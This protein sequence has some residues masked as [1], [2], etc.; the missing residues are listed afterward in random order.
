TNS[1]KQQ[2]GLIEVIEVV[3]DKSM[4]KVIWNSE[5]ICSGD[6]LQ[7]SDSSG[8]GLYSLDIHTTG[9][10]TDSVVTY[11]GSMGFEIPFKSSGKVTGGFTPL[12]LSDGSLTWVWNFGFQMGWEL[13]IIPGTLYFEPIGG[14]GL[15]VANQTYDDYYGFQSVAN[16]YGLYLNGGAGLK[17]Y[18]DHEN[19]I[20]L[21]LALVAQWGPYFSYWEDEDQDVTVDVPDRNF[22][23]SGYGLQFTVNIPL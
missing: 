19:G 16:S 12:T 6:M 18:L 13:P 10:L 2:I 3:E 23:I 14:A 22:G 1:F 17:Y 8:W 20:R 15:G 5:V 21:E 7:E 4:A 11:E 9:T